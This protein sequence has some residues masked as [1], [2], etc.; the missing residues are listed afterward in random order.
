M[1][2]C[3]FEFKRTYGDI[4]L[5]FI[6][7]HHEEPLSKL[8]KAELRRAEDLRPVCSNCHRMIHRDPNRPISIEKLRN[9]TRCRRPS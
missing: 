3:G 6:E 4:G 1:P 5:D 9:V 2:I 8:R 7:M